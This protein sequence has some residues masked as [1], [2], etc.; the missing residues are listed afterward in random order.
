MIQRIL[1]TLLGVLFLIALF[2][3]TSLLVALALTAGLLAWG[4]LWWRSRGRGGRVIEGEYRVVRDTKYHL[5][6]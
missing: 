2:L 5:R 6:P 1:S 4:W 3:L